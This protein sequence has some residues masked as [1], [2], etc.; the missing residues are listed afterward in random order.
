MFGYNVLSCVRKHKT[1]NDLNNCIQSS[2]Y[3]IINSGRVPNGWEDSD[4]QLFIAQWINQGCGIKEANQAYIMVCTIG[5]DIYVAPEKSRKNM[6]NTNQVLFVK[7]VN[8]QLRLVLPN[9]MMVGPTMT[10]RS[11]GNHLYNL[12]Q[13][14]LVY[15]DGTKARPLVLVKEN[16]VEDV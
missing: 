3:N 1:C 14:H 8:K 11:K 10:G 6:N 13:L 16:Y 9:T 2:L 7:Q 5:K 12:T 4:K 15:C